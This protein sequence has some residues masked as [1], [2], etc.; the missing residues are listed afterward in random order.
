MWWRLYF[1][2]EPGPSISYTF[3]VYF[4]LSPQVFQLPDPGIYAGHLVLCDTVLLYPLADD[5]DEYE[6]AKV[7]ER[8]N[9]ELLAEFERRKKVSTVSWLYRLVSDRNVCSHSS[10]GSRTATVTFFVYRSTPLLCQQTMLR[11]RFV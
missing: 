5:E 6:L 2:G 8:R 10:E 3:F 7:P 4:H 11:S 9:N 1:R